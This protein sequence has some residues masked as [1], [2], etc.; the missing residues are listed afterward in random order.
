MTKPKKKDE[1][2]KIESGVEMPR[3]FKATRLPLADL[4]VNQSFLMPS[5]IKNPSNAVSSA[6]RSLKMGGK[7]PKDA[8]F[9][10]RKMKDGVR[11][12]R[13]S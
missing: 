7:L 13:V 12:W 10:T 11:C 1:A 4:K 5:D 9:S 2:I 6:T 3:R 8:K